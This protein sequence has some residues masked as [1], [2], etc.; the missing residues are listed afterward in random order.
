MPTVEITAVEGASETAKGPVPI[1]IEVT[2]VPDNDPTAI[3]SEDETRGLREWAARVGVQTTRQIYAEAIEMACAV[4]TQTARR[5]EAMDQP[6]RPDEF[7]VQFALSIDMGGDARIVNIN[8]EAQVQV[9]MQ[10]NR[11]ADG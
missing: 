10:W 6:D 5:L 7:E 4:A 11:S 8:S 2:G 9:R 1:R 3:Y